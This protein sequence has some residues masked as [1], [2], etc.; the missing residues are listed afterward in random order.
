MSTYLYNIK[1]I[2]NDKK[3]IYKELK[4][5]NNF[6]KENLITTKLHLSLFVKYLIV[7]N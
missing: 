3:N 4:Y 2:K 5:K 7:K 1:N 6:L